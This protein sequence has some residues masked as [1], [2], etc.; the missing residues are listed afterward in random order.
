MPRYNFI[1]LSIFWH[2]NLNKINE[3][4]IFKKFTLK[5]I[6]KLENGAK[7]FLSTNYSKKRIVH[8][9]LNF[10]K[11]IYYSPKTYFFKILKKIKK[12]SLTL[13]F[14]FEKSALNS[15][16]NHTQTSTG[17]NKKKTRGFTLL[18]F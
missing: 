17:Q 11:K 5:I 3:N 10:E 15:V 16:M 1:L 9:K 2:C 18:K 8:K 7:K 13:I 12:K 14:L 6:K 4:L